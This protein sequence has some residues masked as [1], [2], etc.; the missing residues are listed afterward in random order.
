MQEQER[1]STQKLEST[2]NFSGITDPSIPN[3]ET[4]ARLSQAEIKKKQKE[5]QPSWEQ[6]WITGYT[7]LT[8]GNHK[9]GIFQMSN[10]H[11][12]VEKLKAVKT[13][14]EQGELDKQVEDMKKFSKSHALNLYRQLQELRKAD[15]IKNYIENIPDNY[16][17]I[18]TWEQLEQMVTLAKQETSDAIDTETTGLH[19]EKDEVVGM[20]ITL[21]QADQHYY[22]PFLHQNYNVGQQLDKTEV[23]QY[24]QQELYSDSN[25]LTAMF[26][27]KFDIHMLLK[28]GI[29]FKG[30][31]VD[32]LIAMKILNE[33]ETSYQL[34]KL[35]NKW[36]KYFGY[37]DDSLT[38]EELFSKDPRDFYVNA[39]YRLCYYY[40]CKDT[41]LTWKLWEWQRQQLDKHPKLASVFDKIETPI[42]QVCIDMEQAGM[43]IDMQYATEYKEQLETEIARLDKGIKEFFGDIN[44]NSPK[45][46]QDKLF[47][48]LGLTPVN[49]SK[50][51][52]AAAL[53]QLSKELPEL[54]MVLEYRKQNKLLSSFIDPIPKMVWTDSR[55]H[56]QFDAGGTKTGRFSSDSPNLQNLPYPARPMFKAPEGKLII[57]ID[58][59][60]I[61][62]RVL[63]HMSK[64]PLLQRPYIQGG[65]LYVESAIKLYGE[66]YNM[67]YSQFLESDDQT[68]RDRGLPKHP[69][70]MFK[71]GL[72]AT[73]YET[74]AHG[75]S[76]MLD[77][78]VEDGQQFIDDFHSNFPTAH[79]YAKDS[80]SF[81]DKNS[82]SETMFGR[83]RRYGSFKYTDKKT[84][85]TTVVQKHS[86]LYKQM[87]HLQ[88]QAER[89]LGHPVTNVWKEKKL[90]YKLK[91]ELGFVSRM[92]NMNVRQIVNA[93]T[94]GTAAEILKLSMIA[95]NNLL[96]QWGSEWQMI[97]T[98]HDE[99]LVEVPDSITEEQFTQLERCL[100]HT[101]KLDIP[102]KVDT[103][104]AIRWGQGVPKSEYLEKGLQCWTDKGWLQNV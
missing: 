58:L 1:A 17:S 9:K 32:S 61:E 19:Y 36:G 54:K 31:V 73:M 11:P 84:K 51:V 8:T 93:R 52:D 92:Y 68:W 3:K 90:P 71:Q 62:P 94:Q 13:A 43:P 2:L 60:Q 44:F 82:Y 100:T 91:Q 37:T 66:R 49:E 56:G 81:V 12:D 85:E 39:D 63:A 72:L 41:H 79:Q 98:I 104:V 24:L 67:E 57:G 70:K 102:L 59:S 34:K 97:G 50:S 86:D 87:T 38:F 83:K 22:I 89:I 101:V 88:S 74:S 99:V 40:A 96:K 29:N 26:N 75:L 48:E 33:N 20:S 42:M 53:K 6:V 65:D 95:M 4:V 21:P 18:Q 55:I 35:A 45:Q 76:T 30:T 47:G 28:E 7:M 46:V 78:S 80:I 25:R 77:I 27:A 64:D 16:H 10:T 103:E 69:R 14:I 15:I 5:F 23:I